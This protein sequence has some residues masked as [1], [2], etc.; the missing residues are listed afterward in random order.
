[1]FYVLYRIICIYIHNRY[2]SHRPCLKSARKSNVSPK[3]LGYRKLKFNARRGDSQ[4]AYFKY[5]S[6]YLKWILRINDLPDSCGEHFEFDT[7]FFLQVAH[8]T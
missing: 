2:M 4:D 1:M 6:T 3:L 8:V 5:T 7:P